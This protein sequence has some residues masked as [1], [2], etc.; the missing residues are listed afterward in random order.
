MFLLA[1]AATVHAASIAG[2]ITAGKG[3]SVAYLDAIP[4][5]TFPAPAQQYTMDQKSLLFN[6][7]I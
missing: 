2:Q 3:I 6:P 7:H 4:G 1:A 5:K